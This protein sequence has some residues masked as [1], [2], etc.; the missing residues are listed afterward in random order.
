MTPRHCMLISMTL[1]AAC[2]H[3]DPAAVGSPSNDGEPPA[4]DTT[5]APPGPAA[6]ERLFNYLS[7]SWDTADQSVADPR[8]YEIR[9][10]ICPVEAPELGQR[11][12]YVEQAMATTPHAPYRQRLYV[13]EP[14]PGGRAVDARSRVYELANPSAAVGGCGRLGLASFHGTDALERP[15]CA[16]NL[17]W[18]EE[19]ASFI[20][21][22]NGRECLSTLRGATYATTEVTLGRER[23]DSLDRGWSATDVQLWGSTAGAY[24]FVRRSPPPSL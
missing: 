12:L 8:F 16:V 15:G 9:L 2:A 7:G 5:L 3:Q 24:R 4:T 10:S 23:L 20:G 14:V 1:A 22:T 19:T 21:G 18:N 17:S 6:D 13:I 11:V